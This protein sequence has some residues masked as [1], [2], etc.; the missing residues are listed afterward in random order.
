MIHFWDLGGSKGVAKFGG[1]MYRSV[2]LVHG[3]VCNP[4][5]MCDV[6][7]AHPF[8][9]HDT[10][11]H[12]PTRAL[13]MGSGYLR[14]NGILDQRQR[15]SITLSVESRAKTG[16]RVQRISVG[17]DMAINAQLSAA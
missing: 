4:L 8:T 9:S 16:I 1:S 11:T 14:K 13:R 2:N 6:P 3:R 17:G 12:K 10:Q 5:S 15:I 7:V